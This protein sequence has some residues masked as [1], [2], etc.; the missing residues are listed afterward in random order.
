MLLFFSAAPLAHHQQVRPDG[1]EEMMSPVLISLVTC[2]QVRELLSDVETV[3]QELRRRSGELGGSVAALLSDLQSGI[4]AVRAR[5]GSASSDSD[6]SIRNPGA[7]RSCA[8]L[9]AN[10][11]NEHGAA[12]SRTPS[13]A[14]AAS[15][16][17]AAAQP[18]SAAAA[19]PPREQLSL[20]GAAAA[21]AAAGEPASAGALPEADAS[22]DLE[23][24]PNDQVSPAAHEDP[25]RVAEAAARAQLALE[26]RAAAA[27]AAA[28]EG[29]PSAAVL[30]RSAVDLARLSTAAL[31]TTMCLLVSVEQ[32]VE[33]NSH[34]RSRPP[35]HHLS[36]AQDCTC[37]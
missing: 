1:G 20:T 2:R 11:R 37:F 27:A 22:A 16:E 28:E 15:G 25:D 10:T 8:V 30:Q 14:A 5:L 23:A 26:V 21:A 33:V 17:A 12:R 9:A 29:A 7:A 19:P 31:T 34:R 6:H 35:V 24:L 36:S 13:T 3:S 4:E 18:T 32:G